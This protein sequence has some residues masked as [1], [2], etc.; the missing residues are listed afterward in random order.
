M[1]SAQ[2]QARIGYC[3]Q[4]DV[5]LDLL[6]GREMLALYGRLRGIRECDLAAVIDRTL[7]REE[8]SRISRR[9]F[10]H[11][12]DEGDRP[13]DAVPKGHSMPDFLRVDVRMHTVTSPLSL[14]ST[15]S[16]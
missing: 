14:T 10:H 12:G 6:T 4:T 3:P 7:Y 9:S 13:G 8:V 11:C 16:L 2:Y 1:A 5:A 15:S